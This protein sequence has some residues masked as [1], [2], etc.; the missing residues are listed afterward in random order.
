MVQPGEHP[1][2]VRFGQVLGCPSFRLTWVMFPRQFSLRCAARVQVRAQ[3]EIDIFTLLR[4]SGSLEVIGPCLLL[5]R[6]PMSSKNNV[7]ELGGVPGVV[8]I[9]IVE[10]G[11]DAGCRC[12]AP[13]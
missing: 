13:V 5:C 12:V 11:T 9:G 4:D 6:L 2:G 10:R 3:K 1:V 8:A 7:W